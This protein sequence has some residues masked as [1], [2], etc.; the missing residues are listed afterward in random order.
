MF[1]KYYRRIFLNRG[2]GVASL[3]LD[4]EDSYGTVK[5]SDCNRAVSL[6]FDYSNKKE[7][8]N[9]EFK[10]NKLISELSA[11]KEKLKNNV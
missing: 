8:E 3:E 2:K 9:S 1:K 7:R 11:L 5:I 10:L 4:F 6:S